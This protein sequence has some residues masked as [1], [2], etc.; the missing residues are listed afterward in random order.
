MSAE[1]AWSLSWTNRVNRESSSAFAFHHI[2]VAWHREGVD[3]LPKYPHQYLPVLR[4]KAGV[5]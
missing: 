4:M 1:F 3:L 2:A 5:P